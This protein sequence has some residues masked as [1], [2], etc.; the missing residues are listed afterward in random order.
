MRQEDKIGSVPLMCYVAVWKLKVCKF[1]G[2]GEV[3]GAD[4]HDGGS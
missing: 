2:L 4:H 1:K 3:Q